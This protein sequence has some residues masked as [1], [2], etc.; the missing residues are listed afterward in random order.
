[1]LP[2]SVT[3]VCYHNSPN[4]RQHFARMHRTRPHSLSLRTPVDG[5]G[6]GGPPTGRSSRLSPGRNMAGRSRYCRQCTSGYIPVNPSPGYMH[7][8]YVLPMMYAATPAPMSAMS[9]MPA[10]NPM[11]HM[12]HTHPH[13]APVYVNDHVPLP[14]PPY[15]LYEKYESS[16]SDN[17]DET[18]TTTAM[19]STLHR[20][21]TRGGLSR[22]NLASNMIRDFEETKWIP[23]GDQS[24]EVQ[25][26]TLKRANW[27]QRSVE[28]PNGVI[29][30]LHC[31]QM[32]PETDV[33]GTIKRSAVQ[34]L[35]VTGLVRHRLANERAS[36]ED[37]FSEVG[38]ISYATQWFPWNC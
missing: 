5:T 18:R 3:P 2:T 13:P 15:P 19:L 6:Y 8:P 32:S 14:L 22:S 36:A 30:K 10:I 31:V 16:E 12:A 27:F 17:M 38:W 37:S 9:S 21:T 24:K 29:S 33:Y 20:S 11:M 4:P 1:M 26:W 25:D 7:V 28:L 34:R 35:K 23:L